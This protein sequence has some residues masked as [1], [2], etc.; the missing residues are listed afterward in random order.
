MSRRWWPLPIGCKHFSHSLH[1]DV[2]THQTQA[3]DALEGSLKLGWDDDAHNGGILYM[4]DILGKP[5][6]DTTV[7]S[8]NKLWWPQCEALYA[9][10]YAYVETKDQ[11]WLDWLNLVQEYIYKYVVLSC[12]PGPGVFL[13]RILYL[14]EVVTANGLVLELLTVHFLIHNHAILVTTP[15]VLCGQPNRKARRRR[16]MVWIPEQGRHSV[17][18]M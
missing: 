6:L 11:K 13:I 7:T 2:V 1:L 3:L 9:C 17:Q 12:L 18:R 8:T 10:T 15:K 16:R 4:M 14:L 5:L